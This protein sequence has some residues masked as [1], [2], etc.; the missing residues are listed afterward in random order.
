LG[1]GA[2]LVPYLLGAVPA[3][4]QGAGFQVGVSLGGFRI[5]VAQESP[6]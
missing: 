5:F 6:N 1:L 4:S 3:L 2:N